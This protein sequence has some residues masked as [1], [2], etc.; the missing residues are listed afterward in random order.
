MHSESGTVL[1]WGTDAA[2]RHRFRWTGIW[3]IYVEVIP[4][5]ITLGPTS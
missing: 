2:Q 1:D 5:G 4:I 3:F